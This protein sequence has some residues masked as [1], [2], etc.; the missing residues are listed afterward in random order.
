M[1]HIK[2]AARARYGVELT[3][4]D[5]RSIEHQCRS[6]RYLHFSDN[7]RGRPSHKHA[8]DAKDVARRYEGRM[9]DDVPLVGAHAI[10]GLINRSPA[11]MY[12]LLEASRVKMFGRWE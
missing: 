10:A 7:G 4:D 3:E 8:G 9:T 2:N 12:Y 6:A 5:I 1:T 11:V